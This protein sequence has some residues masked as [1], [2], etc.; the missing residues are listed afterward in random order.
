MCQVRECLEAAKIVFPV[1][2]PQFLCGLRW[3]I[4]QN[5]QLPGAQIT[6]IVLKPETL[7]IKFVYYL[8]LVIWLRKHLHDAFPM[9]ASFLVTSANTS[10]LFYCFLK[11]SPFCRLSNVDFKVCV[12]HSLALNQQYS[13]VTADMENLAA[14]SAGLFA[15]CANG[16]FGAPTSIAPSSS[17][18]RVQFNHPIWTKLC[19]QNQIPDEAQNK[20]YPQ[21]T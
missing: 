15:V 9:A 14:C 2:A 1:A 7:I 21:R 6:Q 17:L 19:K 10:V 18:G 13:L 5:N 4:H 20:Y 12:A 11:P 8:C 3:H 16:A